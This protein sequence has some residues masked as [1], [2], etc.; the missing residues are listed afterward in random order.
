MPAWS[1]QRGQRITDLLLIHISIASVATGKKSRITLLLTIAYLLLL[2][3]GIV[4]IVAIDGPNT[5]IGHTH[6]IIGLLLIILSFC[7]IV[8]RMRFLVD[9]RFKA[10]K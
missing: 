10:W 1:H 6:Y 2:I 3:T 9:E 4:L 8:K 5:T 7:H